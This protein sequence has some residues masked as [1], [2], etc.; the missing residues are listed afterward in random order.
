MSGLLDRLEKNNS[1]EQRRDPED[2]REILIF[3]TP[4]G[5]SAREQIQALVEEIDRKSQG[6]LIAE[7]IKSFH[8]S[9]IFSSQ[10]Y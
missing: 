1:I 9:A 6:V 8:Q 2:R 4:S 7:E 3:F 10:V 5:I